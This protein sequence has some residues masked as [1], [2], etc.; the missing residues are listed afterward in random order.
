MNDIMAL[1]LLRTGFA[2]VVNLVL[3]AMDRRLHRV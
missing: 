1:T 2:A 3:L